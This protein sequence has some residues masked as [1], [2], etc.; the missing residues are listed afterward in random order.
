MSGAGGLADVGLRSTLDQVV[1]AV[2][3]EL[4]GPFFANCHFDSSVGPKDPQTGL[5]RRMTYDTQQ[6][7][8]APLYTE[9]IFDDFRE[10]DGIKLPFKFTI[11]Q[12]G[13]R[14]ADVTVT[15]YKINSGLK[16]ADLGRR[17]L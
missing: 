7:V 4:F 3:L 9:D 12:S 8:G 17:P 1:Q 14:F 6:A 15:E 5:P 2:F 13:K 10:V 16:P 11:N